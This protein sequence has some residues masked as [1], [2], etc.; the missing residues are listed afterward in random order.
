MINAEFI[1]AHLCPLL[2]YYLPQKHF[3]QD[4]LSR[5]IVGLKNKDPICIDNL[6]I[7]A[8]AVLGQINLLPKNIYVSRVPGHLITC[9]KSGIDLF[10]EKLL[11]NSKFN[12]GRSYLT[13]YI[14]APKSTQSNTRD[15]DT[16]LRTIKIPDVDQIK[17]RIFFLID[18]VRTTGASLDACAEILKSHGA[19]TVIRMPLTQTIKL[20]DRPTFVRNEDYLIE[21]IRRLSNVD[22]ELFLAESRTGQKWSDSEIQLLRNEFAKNDSLVRLSS[23]LNRSTNAI[24]T[25]LES[26]GVIQK[27]PEIANNGQKWLPEEEEALI[28]EFKSNVPLNEIAYLHA[29]TTNG[30]RVRLVKLGLISE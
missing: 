25:K 1:E 12:D 11:L 9:E 5:E 29:R 7:K 19:S 23:L 13:R 30:I 15:K 20:L 10:I 26:I 17:G 14:D 16:H 8:F 2:G 27:N 3:I 28:T 6:V 22:W 4:N 21:K 18:D 24:R